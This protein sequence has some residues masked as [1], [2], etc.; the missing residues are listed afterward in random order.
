MSFARC[1][2]AFSARNRR[3]SACTSS[4]VAGEPADTEPSPSSA[5]IQF[6][7][8]DG[9]ISKYAPTCRRFVTG[10]R[11]DYDAV[12]NGLTLPHSSGPVEGNVNRIKMIKRQMYGRANFDLLRKRV[13]LAR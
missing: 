8:V 12:R 6:R 3:N 13:L 5:R 9:L 1:S 4:V 7:I 2:S 10:L 11:R